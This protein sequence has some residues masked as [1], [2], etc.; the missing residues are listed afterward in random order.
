MRKSNIKGFTLLEL[1]VVISIIIILASIV[2]PALH[3]ARKRA[4]V[5]KTKG[6][7]AGLELALSMYE[8]DC[9]SYPGS[10]GVEVEI[11]T[12]WFIGNSGFVNP[13][14]PGWSGPY[15]EFKE[16]E[17]GNPDNI[18]NTVVVDAWGQPLRYIKAGPNRP[19]SYEIIS[20]GSDKIPGNEDDV[21][22]Y[23]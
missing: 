18:H 1:L 16:K 9:G 22:N 7:I 12:N 20:N 8:A 13:G 14:I 2:M 6:V 23:K 4:Y 5:T 10:D 17:L 19:Q 21:A 15:A 11:P 3:K